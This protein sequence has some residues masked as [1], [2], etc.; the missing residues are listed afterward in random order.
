TNT[1]NHFPTHYKVPNFRV[2]GWGILTNTACASPYRGA[3]RVEA[4]FSMDRILD[5]IAREL[6]LDPVEVRRRNIVRVADMPYSSGL[7]Y[8][9]GVPVTYSGLNFEKLLDAA[10]ERGDYDGWRKR[11]AE[12]RTRGRHVGIGVASYV[13]AGGIGPCEGATV[14]V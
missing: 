12:L 6:S 3:G 11:Q 7:I 1:V 8:R 10:L 2:E 13:E 9:D 4:V 14:S 5:G